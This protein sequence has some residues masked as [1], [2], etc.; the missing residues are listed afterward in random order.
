M[1]STL[2]LLLLMLTVNGGVLFAQSLPAVRFSHGRL[3][4][5]TY[6]FGRAET[7]APLFKSLES[8]GHYPYTALDPSSLSRK[9]RPV[10]YE[11]LTLENEYLRVVFLPELGGRIWSA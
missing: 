3:E 9:P 4:V 11:S 8:M 7:V 6:T 10:S 1:F 2:R 5:P